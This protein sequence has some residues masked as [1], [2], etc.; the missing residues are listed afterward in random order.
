MASM[1][2]T[3]WNENKDYM[4]IVTAGSPDEL[5]RSRTVYQSILLEQLNLIPIEEWMFRVNEMHDRVAQTAVQI[6]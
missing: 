4:S 6:C 5:R 2:T 1:G 3:D